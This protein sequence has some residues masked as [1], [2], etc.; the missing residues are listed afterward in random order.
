MTYS[1][2][3][4]PPTNHLTDN[5]TLTK[6]FNELI[7][8]HSDDDDDHQSRFE[9]V[10]THQQPSSSSFVDVNNPFLHAP[11]HH[12]PVQKKPSIETSKPIGHDSASNM[13]SIVNGTRSSAFAPY[14]RS[15]GSQPIAGNSVFIN[16]P[17]KTN[18]PTNQRSIAVDPPAMASPQEASNRMSYIH[19]SDEELLSPKTRSA[20]V[21]TRLSSEQHA[22]ANLSFNDTTTDEYF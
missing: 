7:N 22:Y 4:D 21:R 18:L 8:E 9:T 6:G 11:F 17:F 1:T 19:S 14:Q 12:S 20:E 16:A 2:T 10:S 15:V 5:E 13:N 3:S